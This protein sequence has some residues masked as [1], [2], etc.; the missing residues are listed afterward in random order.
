MKVLQVTNVD[1]SLRH[2]LLPL[3]RAVRARGHE[4]VGVSADAVTDQ[5]TGVPY[6]RA[7]V[8]IAQDQLSRLGGAA[9]VPG[10][11]VEVFIQTG[12]R[13]PMAYL[14]KP[15]TDYFARALRET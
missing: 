6:Y 7:E 4:V 1:F 11:P 14:L 12:E 8:T 5:A 2:F 10:M 15:L 3:M 13:S 9:L